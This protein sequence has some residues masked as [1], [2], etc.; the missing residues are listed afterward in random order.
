MAQI[1]SHRHEIVGFVAGI[2][3]HH[4]LV[5]GALLLCI[6]TLDASV[7]V[8]ALFVECGENS[9]SLG[10]EFEVAAVIAYTLDY[11]AGDIH[12]IDIGLAFDFTCHHD[13][14]GGDEGLA[15]YFGGWIVGEKFVKNGIGNLVGNFVGVSFG[16]RF[17]GEKIIFVGHSV[18]I[19]SFVG[20]EGG[21]NNKGFSNDAKATAKYSPQK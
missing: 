1:E 3:E 7:Y 19:L 21:Q 2:S 16:N 4:A 14:S 9:A 15:G 8:L 11:S 6:G 20:S 10:I 18:I 5:A 13:L 17:G 12:Q